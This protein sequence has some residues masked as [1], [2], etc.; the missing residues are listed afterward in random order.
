MPIDD[1]CAC[2][3]GGPLECCGCKLP[4]ARL[5]I[6]YV[7]L[8]EGGKQWKTKPNAGRDLNWIQY[9]MFWAN[10]EQVG[11]VLSE[12]HAVAHSTTSSQVPYH[13]Q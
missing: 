9:P 11:R 2:W 3:P 5:S 10:K 6:D 4:P 8:R 13:I 12:C 7:T 1:P